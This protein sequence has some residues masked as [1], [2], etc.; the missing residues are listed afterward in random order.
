MVS[1]PDPVTLP[2]NAIASVVRVRSVPL[3]TAPSVSE[4]A[5][6]VKVLLFASSA[7]SVIVPPVNAVFALS[8]DVPAPVWLTVML[9]VPASWS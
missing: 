9:F 1:V 4:S 2:F 6:A 8:F 7:A 3:V 5:L